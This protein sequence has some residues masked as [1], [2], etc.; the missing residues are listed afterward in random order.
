VELYFRGKKNTP[1]HLDTK[2]R[3]VSIVHGLMSLGLSSFDVFV[4]KCSLSDPT[5]NFQKK[6]LLNSVGYFIYDLI[7]CKYYDLFDMDLLIHHTIS[8]F[9]L[10]VGPVIGY[11]ASTAITGIVISEV[12]NF[13]M[14]LRTILKN[15]GLKH[16][17]LHDVLEGIYFFLYIIA[18]AFFGPMLVYT[19]WVAPNSPKV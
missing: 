7:A 19:S 15:Y 16:T 17:L 12:S 8:C 1:E 18:R 3:I 13:P 5:T 9:G 10:L 6:V 4:H 14:H 11:G 2:N